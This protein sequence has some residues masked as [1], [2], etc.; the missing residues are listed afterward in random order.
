MELID[1]SRDGCLSDTNAVGGTHG[2]SDPPDQCPKDDAYLGFCHGSITMP[3]APELQ[4]LWD[5]TE[6]FGSTTL[7]FCPP[8]RFSMNCG[9]AMQ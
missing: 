1:I 7:L 8:C 3:P 5:N 4:N 6:P 2:T 9:D